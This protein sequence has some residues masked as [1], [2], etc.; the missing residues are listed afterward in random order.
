MAGAMKFGLLGPLVAR[1]GEIEI[2]VRRGH[3]RA[4]LATLLL[5]A[6][7][8]VSVEA[9]TEALWG[10]APPQSAPVAI[11]GYVRWLRLAFGPAG[12]DRIIT[13]PHGY[14]IRV[15]D[16]EF[17]LTRFDLLVVSARAAARSGNWQDA[18]D[19]ARAALSFW[20]G[21]PLADIESDA[22]ARREIPR[23]SELRLQAVEIRIE[24]ELQLGRH[25]EVTAELQHLCAAHPM[26]EH[27]HALLML[28]LYRCGRQAE[29]LAAYQR[30]RA[31]L[32]DELG[33]DPGSELQ[34]L[35]QRILA[36]H[37]ALAAGQP[38]LAAGQPALAAGQP[39]PTLP[40]RGPGAAGITVPRQLPAAV[41]RFTG[42][43]AELAVLGSLLTAGPGARPPAVVISA[44][45]GTAGV[46]KTAMA[47]HW[48]HRVAEQFPDGQLYVNLRG[49]NTDAPVAT[50]DALA[51]FLQALGVHGLDIP[52]EPEDRARLYRSML[53][54][55]RVLVVLDNARDSDQVRPLL[56]G[57]PSCIAVVTSRNTLAGLV[58]TDGAQRLDLDVLPLPDAVALLK[59]LIG[60][61]ADDDPEA[62]AALAQVCARLPLALRIAAELVVARTPEPLAEL[63]SE[64][65][66]SQLDSLDSGED[67]A[68]VRTVFSWSFRQLPQGVASAFALLGLHPGADLG[69]HATAALIGTTDRQA[70][71]VL[72]R[73]HGASMLHATGPGR[74]GMHDLLRVYA[75]EQAA[76]S[77]T[78]GSCQRA[79][80]RL[81]DHYMSAAAAATDVLFPA[82]SRHRPRTDPMAAAVHG[83][84]PGVARHR[85]GE[86]RHR[87]RPLRRPWLAAARSRP[88]Q[89]SVQLPD[90][91]QPPV[92][93][94]HH[95]QPRVARRPPGQRRGRRGRSAEWARRH[96]H[97]ERPVSRSGQPLPSRT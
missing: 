28:A 9:I 49:Y 17:D 2:P 60:A 97:D 21:E 78:N 39:A 20:R 90:E 53:A 44:I 29:A 94:A 58:A 88:G 84:R 35:H 48:G 45:A 12:R 16:D 91:R 56:P 32:V 11:R 57:D 68:D 13:E 65:A 52:H 14:L 71:Q 54:G 47:V 51:G 36:A 87:R 92:R 43:G 93:G 76:A 86:P 72:G 33:A 22:L 64:L 6:N 63:A 61:R 83:I 40:A 37:P 55:R 38:A 30:V 73:L 7:R 89:H 79:L 1:S 42:R 4:L 34:I 23:L 10:P 85:A 3:P 41:S 5:H 46:G 59:S 50:A 19:G 77:D 24:A 25:A 69:I 81:F 74:Y 96:R 75:R 18:A 95:I 8:T 27:L 31:V 66:A 82:D 70:R 26:R 67:R 80:T 62:V 15:A